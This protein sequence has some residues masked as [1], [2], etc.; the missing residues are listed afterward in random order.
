MFSD[1]IREQ[2]LD[3][4]E[5][6]NLIGWSQDF[7]VERGNVVTTVFSPLLA[8]QLFLL[9]RYHCT[10][11]RYRNPQQVVLSIIR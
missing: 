4:Y 11:S 9:S 10:A 2:M 1:R 3:W 8:Q 7:F 5:E 6:Y